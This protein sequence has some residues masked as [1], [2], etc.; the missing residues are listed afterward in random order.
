M[1]NKHLHRLLLLFF[2]FSC[3]AAQAQT[4]ATFR[5]P[6]QFR[7]FSSTVKVVVDSAQCESGAWATYEH[8]KREIVISNAGNPTARTLQHSLFHEF[9]H[10][11]LQH[12]RRSDLSRNEQLVEMIAIGLEQFFQQLSIEEQP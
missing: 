3:F 1:K 7:I 4:T 12:C 10:C 6:T 9:S 2:V 11:L 8:R 5:I